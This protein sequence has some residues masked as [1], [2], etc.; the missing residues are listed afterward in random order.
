MKKTF[1]FMAAAL[2]VASSAFANG[3]GPAPTVAQEYVV[4]TF[5]ASGHV[6]SGAGWQRYKTQGA[7]VV[8]NDISGTLPGVIGEYADTSAVTSAGVNREDVFRFFVD[9]FELD[10]AKTFGENIRVRADLDFGSETL[11]SG[12]RFRSPGNVNVYIEQ[13]YVTANLAL[14]DGLELLVGRFNSPIGYEQNDVVANDTIFRSF[15]YRA[16]RAKS[17]TGLKFYYRFSDLFDWALWTANNPL[18]HDS[19]DSVFLQT[20]IPSVGTRFGF[21]W[22]DEGKESWLGFGGVWGQDHTNRKS[23]WSFYGDVDANFWITDDFR[24]SAEAIYR[25]IDTTVAASRNGKYL[26]GLANFHYNFSDVWDGTL[27]YAYTHD[28][29]GAH[30]AGVLV[31]PVTGAANRTLTGIVAGGAAGQQAHEVALGTNYTITDGA[32]LRLEGGWTYLDPQGATNNQ[33]I[34]GF[35]GGFAYEF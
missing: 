19:G 32:R 34:F 2:V 12:V 16:L 18:I 13:A 6:F 17:F 30:N 1:L 21:H 35:A 3:T 4:G 11:F 15:I 14:G 5:E 23:A 9:E 28:I 33:H 31:T 27:K 7:T 24:I 29:N 20:D 10:I 26:G 22:G 8:P 25:Q